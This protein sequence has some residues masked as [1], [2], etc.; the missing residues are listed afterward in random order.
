ML[1]F[2][3]ILKFLINKKFVWFFKFV[4][5]KFIVLVIFVKFSDFLVYMFIIHYKESSTRFEPKSIKF[6]KI[7]FHGR[8]T[9]FAIIQFN[10]IHCE[11][12]NPTNRVFKKGFSSKDSRHLM[13]RF[14]MSCLTMKPFSVVDHF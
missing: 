8:K 2:I 4:L 10:Y 12:N 9:F 7:L 14:S 13:C 11:Q 5:H 1:K 3:I 6:N